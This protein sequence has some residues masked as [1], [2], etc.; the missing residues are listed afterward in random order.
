MKKKE[1]VAKIIEVFDETYPEAGCTLLY[2]DPLQ[3]LVSTILAAQSTDARVNMITPKLFEKY[4]NVYDFADADIY[5]LQDIIR[6][7][8]FFRNKSKNIIACCKMIAE[9]YNGKVPSNM[10][11]LLR[12]P[13]V[14]RKTANVVLGDVFG[15]PGIVVDTHCGRLA[16]RIGF[17]KHED[18]AKVEK[19]LMNIIPREY[20][21]KFSHQLVYHGRALCNARKPKCIE[22]KINSWCDTGKKNKNTV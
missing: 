18:P 8:G 20:W 10:D 2:E 16:R 1:K 19:D 14:G 11:D 21:T 13:G 6:T 7:I 5:E 9:E 12:L 4:R 22:C 3:L 15:I 17:T